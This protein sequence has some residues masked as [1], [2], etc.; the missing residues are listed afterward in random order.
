[1]VVLA[2]AGWS[3]RGWRQS[4]WWNSTPSGTF[5]HQVDLLDID[6]GEATDPVI[7]VNSALVVWVFGGDR[8]A[9]CR[10]RGRAI[11][12]HGVQIVG[13]SQTVDVALNVERKCQ[14]LLDAVVVNGD[15]LVAV[16]SA[17]LVVQS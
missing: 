5:V 7:V 17:L 9:A 4:G 11:M 8:L 2:C 13:R 12:H 16:G 10:E 1:V 3:L 15:E 6:R 14:S